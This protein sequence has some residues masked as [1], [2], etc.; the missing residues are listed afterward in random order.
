MYT[1]GMTIIQAHL[2]T[3]YEAC[4]HIDRKEWKLKSIM[5]QSS[6]AIE[7]DHDPIKW[8]YSLRIDIVWPL[9]GIKVR[10]PSWPA[11]DK[12]RDG[13]IPNYTSCKISRVLFTEQK[14]TPCQHAGPS[15]LTPKA[16]VG[17]YSSLIIHLRHIA[18]KDTTFPPF[19][20]HSRSR[21]RSRIHSRCISHATSQ[22]FRTWTSSSMPRK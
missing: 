1:V 7:R 5:I 3:R 18:E 16:T 8:I 2:C 19:R 20:I 4:R 9:L 12:G 17:R 10:D 15:N 11:L 22:C 6:N 13:R 21:P 14:K